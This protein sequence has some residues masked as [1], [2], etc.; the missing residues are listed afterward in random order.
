MILWR[1]C[2]R[3]Q[4]CF[5]RSHAIALFL[6]AR[7]YARVEGALEA[8]RQPLEVARQSARDG[9]YNIDGT[10]G[11]SGVVLPQDERCSALYMRRK[12]SFRASE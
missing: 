1:A 10:C 2:R 5:R 7:P 9:E 8:M 3:A 12:F 4:E 11:I 6:H